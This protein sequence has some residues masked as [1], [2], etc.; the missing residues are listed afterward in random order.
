MNATASD[1][2]IQRRWLIALGLV[3]AVAAVP[4]FLGYTLPN[5]DR[6]THIRW[7]GQAGEAIR[8]GVWYA[9]WMPEAFGGLGEMSYSAYLLHHLAGGAL[10]AAGMD[11]W[12]AIRGL[13]LFAI[14]VPVAGVAWFFAARASGLVAFTL[15]CVSI[16]SAPLWL[17]LFTH[18]AAYPWHL[19]LLVSAAFL[20]ASCA[21]DRRYSGCLTIAALTLAMVLAHVLVAM[22]TLLAVG[23]AMAVRA[24]IALRSN[25]SV[26]NELLWLF[27]V[28]LGIGLSAFHLVPALAARE[29][30]NPTLA[31]ASPYLDWRNSF[32]FPLFSAGEHGYRWFSVQWVH[33][34]AILVSLGAVAYAW[35]HAPMPADARD[36]IGLLGLTALVAL[37]L[38]A[39]PSW[40]LYERVGVL[41][42]VQWPYRFATVA[43]L[44]AALAMCLAWVHADALPRSRAVLAVA[45]LVQGALVVVLLWQALAAGGQ[46]APLAK[47][48][49]EIFFQ[50]GNDLRTMRPGWREYVEKG[51]LQ[52]EC[53][54]IGVECSTTALNAH[55]KH[56]MIKHERSTSVRLPL[57]SNP[58]WGV[59]L[60]GQ[61]VEP[62][63]DAGSGLVVV[64]LH[65]SGRSDVRLDFV[66]LPQ[67]ALGRWTSAVALLVVMVL[68]ALAARSRHGRHGP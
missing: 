47:R 39:E 12:V 67:E 20:A 2:S 38:S 40:L 29:L 64:R 65:N 59:R 15:A 63:V 56:F 7:I 62:E 17:F 19:G 25:R 11:P 48:D 10:V 35:R 36:Q 14:A 55:R 23:G 54:R 42:A 18:H 28:V 37:V 46:P 4:V 66:G 1:S 3:L 50:F 43:G 45:T 8:A 16:A 61:R 60:N 49:G 53:R 34:T 58:A 31:A 33:P 30:I 52:A 24:V 32:T 57:I 41:R 9:R 44:A 21:R 68:I 13:G 22:M 26:G 5:V 51:G 27:G 6:N